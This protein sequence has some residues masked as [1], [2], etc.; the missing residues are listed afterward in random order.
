MNRSSRVTNVLFT[1][2][3]AASVGLVVAVLAIAGVFDQPERVVR[4][5]AP[6]QATPVSQPRAANGSVSDIYAKTAPGV[7]FIEADGGT[8]SANGGGGG[9]SG[10]GFL[11]DGQGHVVT[12]EHVVDAGSRYT[13]RF[14]E[15]GDP[16]AAKLVGKDPSTDL[17]VLEVD[18]QKISAETKPLELAA[19]SDL[20][21]GDAA[22]AIG[23]PFGLSGTVTTGVISAL[24]REIESPNGFPI[25]GVLQT[26]AAINPGNSGGP[27]LDAQ[28][29]VI[30]VNSQIASGSAQQNSGVGFAVPVD[31]IKDVVPQ[32]IG[33]GNIERA[34]LG[35]STGQVQ[36]QDG[37]VVLSIAQG[38][39]AAGTDLRPGDRIVDLAGRA[40]KEPADLS[41]AVLDHKPGDRVKLTVE[42]NGDRRTI[43]V[44][45]GTRPDQTVQG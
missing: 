43:D 36:T 4:E 2:L 23:S 27:L 29:R 17:A 37:A 33:G 31:T 19:S 10:S 24:D 14:G 38:G 22:I 5:P 35:V 7:A 42:R 20:R 12:N 11:I 16:L 26:D 9:A 1:F 28:G 15:D 32:L 25:S 18:P 13:V 21:P 44:Q 34:Y 6:A 41:S 3:G 45:L 39:P 8:A 30:G 40:I